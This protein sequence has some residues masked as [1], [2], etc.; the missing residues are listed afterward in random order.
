MQYPV[1][2]IKLGSAVLTAADGAISKTVIK[3]VAA[4]IAELSARYRVVLVSSG[5]VGSGKAY[6]RNY[7]GTLTER[8]AAAAIGNPLLIQLYQKYFSAH[9]IPVAQALCERHHFSSRPQFLQLKETFDT[10]WENGILPVVNENDLVSNVELKF[11]DNDE[12]A[13]LLAISFDADSLLLCTSAG[14]FMDASQ[15]IIPLVQKI[16]STILGYV[17]SDK[18]SV[19]LGGMTS[20][21]TFTRLAS[22][23]G[24]RVVICGLKGDTP[25]QDAM[26]QRNGTT[27]LPQQSNLKARQKWLA[28]GSITIGS[29]EVDKGA[30]K[31]LLQRKSLLTV[32]IKAI[33]GRFETGEVVQLTNEEQQIIGVAKVKMNYLAIMENLHQKNS[34]AAHADDIVVF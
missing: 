34:V 18:S 8:K 19:G 33:S 16:D 7:K 17:R 5:A 30:A 32:G 31:A 6:I 20:K 23:L 2:V 1:L 9:R 22:S 25:F 10:F 28:S 29:I 11:S 27:F 3:K 12:L 13:T 14:G 4:G 24:I 15:N 21:L 26:Q